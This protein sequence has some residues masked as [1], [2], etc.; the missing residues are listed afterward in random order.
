ATTTPALVERTAAVFEQHG[1]DAWYE[2]AADEFVPPDLTCRCGSKTFERERDILDVWFDSGSSHL[3]VLEQRPDLGWP[4]DLYLEGT[5]QYRGW[6]QSSLLVGIGTRA[7][8]P[9][10]QVLTHGF[11]VDEQG[12]KMSKSLGN[13]VPPQ[14]V[15]QKSGA[16]VLRLWAAMVDY[17]DEVRLGK[18]V[19]ARVVEAYRKVRN[20][21]RYLVSN[22]YDFDPAIDAM[23]VAELEEV[24]RF[25]LAR[26]AEA[27][28]RMV[29]A[30]ERY[31]YPTIF[32]TLNTLA[33][34]DLSAFY[35]DVSK[36]RLY[37]LAARSRARR[38]AQTAVYTIADG[39]AR[40]VAPVLPV[41]CEELWRHLPGTRE[42]SVHLALF[43]TN[44][45]RMED[46]ALV[47]RW[48]EL[49][50]V[51]DKVNVVLE[52]A[53]QQKT[54]G[55]SLTAKVTL[56]AGGALGELL[57]RYRDDLPMLFIVS[58]VALERV[59][60]GTLDIAVAKADGTKCPRCW[61]IVPELVSTGGDADDE[62][63]TRCADAIAHAVA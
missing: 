52:G 25:A 19:L 40:L 32:H 8:A 34:V 53:R 30:Y 55:N 62:L 61:R 43:P 14:D 12:R 21:M 51:R 46:P 28:R 48:T 39:L 49:N 33:T 2:R 47:D 31:D 37:T 6:F 60:D 3:A 27:G 16:E 57:A 4:A 13:F 36:D 23:P 42:Q 58:E 54:I 26:Y 20:T 11:V 44:L 9:Y 63:C 41:T 17:R 35:L 59:A 15:I 29:D 7:R 22:L 18:E 45:G 56:R 50:A 38:S 24:D 5:D 1:A 10:D